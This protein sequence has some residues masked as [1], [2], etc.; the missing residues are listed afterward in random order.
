ML[1][2]EKYNYRQQFV[3]AWRGEVLEQTD[4]R[5]VLRAEWT[6]AAHTEGDLTFQPG[7]RL[8]EYFYT[9]CPFSIWELHGPPATPDQAALGPLK[10]W[11]CNICAPMRLDS[12]P[13]HCHDL[14][15]DVLVYPDGSS[16][17]RDAEE[18]GL[19]RASDLTPDLAALA[20]SAVALVREWVEQ[21][22]GPFAVLPAH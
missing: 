3:Y 19:A 9:T 15:L 21:R 20:E 18:F 16:D 7:D 14:I 17:V 11:Y 22:Q 12:R 8:I 4:Q 6:R 1:A 5:L 13:L 2:V 10:G